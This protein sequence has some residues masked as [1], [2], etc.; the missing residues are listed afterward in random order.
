MNPKQ[1]MCQKNF[2]TNLKY[3]FLENCDT[4]TMFMK[5]VTTKSKAQKG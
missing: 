5:S 2:K 4:F 3:L 1:Q